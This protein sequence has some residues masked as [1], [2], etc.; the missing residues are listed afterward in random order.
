MHY[1]VDHEAIKE[2][3]PLE[4]VTR[5]LLEIYQELLGLEIVLIKVCFVRRG[6]IVC[7][8]VTQSH[9]GQTCASVTNHTI[10]SHVI[11]GRARLA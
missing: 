4:R 10:F 8:G 9:T 6:H 3:F 2:Y 7:A 11:V 1:N 5:G